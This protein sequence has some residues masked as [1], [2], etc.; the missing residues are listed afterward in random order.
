MTVLSQ[1]G[2]SHDPESQQDSA[3]QTVELANQQYGNN[4]IVGDENNTAALPVELDEV[5]VSLPTPEEARHNSFVNHSVNADGNGVG[6]MS[7]SRKSMNLK[8]VCIGTVLAL[9][10]LVVVVP[11]VALSQSSNNGASSNKAATTPT[12]NTNTATGTS[13]TLDLD[14][15]ASP[16]GSEPN[17]NPENRPRA[18]LQDVIA[19]MVGQGVSNMED[20]Q[21]ESSPQARAASW[22]ATADPANW[23]VP[24]SNQYNIESDVGYWYMTRYIMVVNYYALGGEDWADQMYFLTKADVCLWHTWNDTENYRIGVFCPKYNLPDE[25]IL[26]K[27]V[28]KIV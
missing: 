26:G 9:V 7:N 19:Y 22:L 25:L 1:S 23:P 24:D 4:N 20:F 28:L 18:N 15:N 14:S 8:W 3:L 2:T 17:L 5:G 12:T 13:Q 10:V 27:F 6:Q 11:A 21:N 16:P